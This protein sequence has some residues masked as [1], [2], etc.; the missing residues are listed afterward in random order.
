MYIINAIVFDAKW[1]TAY[2]KENIFK[3]DFTSIDGTVQKSQLMQSKESKYLE[4]FGATGFIKPYKGNS[5]SFVALLPNEDISINDFIKNMDGTKF[6]SLLDNASSEAVEAYLPKFSYDYEVQMN[7][8]LKNM[9]MLDAFD[10]GKADFSKLGKSSG[11]NIFVSNV[12][13]KTFISVDELGTKAGAVTSVEY[14]VTSVQEF[15]TV[16]LDRPFLYAIIDNSTMLPVFI[17][18]VLSMD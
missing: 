10:G 2:N 17:G 7:Q 1:E 4:G 16:R 3:A 18:S 14:S 13:H 5:Y 9:G 15:K 6:L 11:G 12:L 8:S